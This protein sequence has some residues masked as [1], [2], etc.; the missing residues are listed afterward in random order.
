MKSVIESGPTKNKTFKVWKLK[1]LFV[2]ISIDVND[3]CK[4]Y[5]Q[6]H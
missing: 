4:N 3:T 2:F 5:G 6:I 1:V